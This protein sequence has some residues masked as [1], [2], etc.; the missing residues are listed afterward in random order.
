MKTVQ[1]TLNERGNQHGKF[2][3]NARF[4]QIVKSVMRDY[5]SWNFLSN[6]KREALEMIA[7]KISRILAGDSNHADH[8]RDIAGYAT[9]AEQSITQKETPLGKEDTTAT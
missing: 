6:E 9:L 4:S 7:H 5:K 2:A 1:D 8:W 3:D